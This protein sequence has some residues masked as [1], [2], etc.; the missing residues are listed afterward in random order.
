MQ[1]LECEG[2]DNIHAITCDITNHEQIKAMFE[3]IN[4]KGGGLDINV[5]NAGMAKNDALL[6]VLLM[7][8]EKYLR[9]VSQQGQ[10]GDL[11]LYLLIFVGNRIVLSGNNVHGSSLN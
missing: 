9:S 11:R 2:K 3:K 4:E 5:N 10:T 7:P 6:K 8:G 1:Q